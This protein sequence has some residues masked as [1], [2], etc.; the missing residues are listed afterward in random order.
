[1]RES[2]LS[3]SAAG[4]GALRLGTRMRQLT[5]A[6]DLYHKEDG[7][8]IRQ[9]VNWNQPIETLRWLLDVFFRVLAFANC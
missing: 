2:S 4:E 5:A 6:G 3:L 1:M 7:E 9:F 8:V